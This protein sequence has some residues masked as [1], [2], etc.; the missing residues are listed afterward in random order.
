MTTRRQ[1]HPVG[2]RRLIRCLDQLLLKYAANAESRY[3]IA[4][5]HFDIAQEDPADMI[6][7]SDA[8]GDDNQIMVLCVIRARAYRY[9]VRFG[10]Q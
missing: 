6:E 7:A 5:D 4:L 1:A 3:R 9:I 10:R 8:N 2:D